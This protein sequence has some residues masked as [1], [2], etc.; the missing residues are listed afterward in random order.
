MRSKQATMFGLFPEKLTTPAHKVTAYELV[1]YNY[2][3][4][5]QHLQPG[6]TLVVPVPRHELLSLFGVHA[7]SDHDSHRS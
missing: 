3:A 2:W 1:K 7:S 6:S 4:D 5:P